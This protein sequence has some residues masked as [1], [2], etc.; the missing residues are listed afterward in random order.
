MEAMAGRS[1]TGPSAARP[2]ST[3]EYAGP[4]DLYSRRIRD[5]CGG[6]LHL[7]SGNRTILPPNVPYPRFNNQ[8][9]RC[10]IT[11]DLR[12]R[13]TICRRSV[14]P[15]GRHVAQRQLQSFAHHG[16][17]APAPSPEH[18]HI[19]IFAAIANLATKG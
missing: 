15:S 12:Y 7:V 2:Q 16:T 4:P 8:C 3:L 18:A 19:G 10:S 9:C 1:M 14:E 6:V 11:S 5:W 13:P 17:G